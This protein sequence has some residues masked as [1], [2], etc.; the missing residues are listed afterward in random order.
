MNEHVEASSLPIEAAT[1]AIETVTET[2][3]PPNAVNYDVRITS[4]EHIHYM[5]NPFEFSQLPEKLQAVLRKS[6]ILQPT[7]IQA[8]S[9]AA[10]REGYDVLAQSMTGSG[11]TLAFALPIAITLEEVKRLNKTNLEPRALILTPTRELA[12]QIGKVFETLLATC[13]MRVITIVG[14]ASYRKQEGALQSGVDIVVGTPGRIVD[15]LERGSLALNS[16]QTYVLDEVD[17][18]L[19]IG[20]AKELEAVRDLLPKKIQTLFFS[21]TLNPTATRLAG[22]LLRTPVQIRMNKIDD[23]TCHIEHGYAV[24]R[25]GQKF[26]AL[27]CLLTY[28]RPSQG[29]IFCET[30]KE[31]NEISQALKKKGLQ[32]APLNSDLGH[33]DRQATMN[34]FKSGSLQFLVATD[35]AARGIDV[36]GLPLIIN[37]SVPRKVD[38]YTHRVGRTGRAGLQGKAWTLLSPDEVGSYERMLIQVKRKAQELVLPTQATY[39]QT[40]IQKEMEQLK[41]VTE[42]TGALEENKALQ[43]DHVLTDLAPEACKEMLRSILLR[44]IR[45]IHP[46]EMDKLQIPRKELS[47]QSYGYGGSRSRRPFSRERSGGGGGY[48][49]RRSN[50]SGPVS[51]GNGFYGKARP[52]GSGESSFGGRG[53]FRRDPSR[54]SR[55]PRRESR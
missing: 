13:G 6:G 31:C 37:F 21:A 12:E 50:A 40:V 8:M 51:S 55:P 10:V 54:D 48:G 49:D 46:E 2:V 23:H 29:I 42:V 45:G 11:K 53:G 28:F 9:Y 5:E 38:S 44:R 32:A 52:G 20:F 17:Q 4:P 26:Q 30:K 14:G 22:S 24:I 39:L 35:V 33:Y 34:Q 3:T 36:Q 25:S 7:P 43:I 19:D 1:L 47:S 15:L 18:M 27:Y 41:L 16:I